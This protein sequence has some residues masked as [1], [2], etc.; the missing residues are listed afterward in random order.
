M[1]L[2]RRP[3]RGATVVEV[4][5]IAPVILLLLIGLLVGGLG[6]FRYQQVAHAAREA[7][8][9][10]AVHGSDY[11][12]ETGNPAA[13]ANDVYTQAVVPN[14]TGLD[15]DKLTCSV[16][17][18][19]NKSPYHTATVNGQTRKITNTVSVTIT[20]QW[21]PEAYLGGVTLRSTSVA[22]MSY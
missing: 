9:W 2:K 7:S 5:F 11:A 1:N 15:A 12:Q 22:V 17:W 16:T 14:V 18:D 4:A 20:Y 8:R 19:T 3:R 21:L 10:A 6:V 13:T